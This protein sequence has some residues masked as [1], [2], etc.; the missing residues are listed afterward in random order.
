LQFHFE[1][2]PL[3]TWIGWWAHQLP[4]WMQKGATG[5]MFGIELIVP[6]L[7][8]GPRRVRFFAFWLFVGLQAVIL[9]T[10]NYCFFNWLTILL[11][12]PLL[13]DFRLKE[14]LPRRWRASK[15]HGSPAPPVDGVAGK[16]SAAWPKLITIA[17]V[18]VFCGISLMQAVGMFGIRL[19]WPRPFLAAYQWAA[20]FRTINHYGLFA[21]MTTERLEIIVEGSEDGRDWRPYQFKYKPGDLNQRPRFVAPHQPRLDWQMWFAALSDYRQNP[22][23]INFCVRLLEGSPK[24]LRLLKA[25]PFPNGPPKYMRAMAY[26][27][28]FT[29]FKTWRQSGNWWRRELKG[30]Y[31]PP[32]S[33]KGTFGSAS[34]ERPPAE[35][36]L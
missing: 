28:H 22:W 7:I 15:N 9:L 13:D 10:G 33:L 11:C 27:Y 1:T 18:I 35:R 34:E 32:I 8:F 29:D 31:L 30:I 20:P 24:V 26:Q 12:I 17:V 23:L 21:V 4:E 3:P 5:F 36:G 16:A 6:F 25:N 2:Q 19:P 14:M